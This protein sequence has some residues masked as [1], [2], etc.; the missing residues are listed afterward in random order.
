MFQHYSQ[1]SDM[2]LGTVV[3]ESL[4]QLSLGAENLKNSINQK[5]HVH[6]QHVDC[7]EQYQKS[8]S[9]LVSNYTHYRKHGTYVEIL[10][11]NRNNMHEATYGMISLNNQM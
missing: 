9:F 5:K 8:R 1:S 10:Q 4:H 7:A 2:Y 6:T 11:T 3:E